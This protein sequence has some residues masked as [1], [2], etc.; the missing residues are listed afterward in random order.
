MAKK[1]ILLKL[2][3]EVFGKPH[4]PFSA[5]T[6]INLIE[7]I[8]EL[9]STHQF[10]IV[11]GGGNLFRGSKQGKELGLTAKNAHQ[12]GMLATIMN[13]VIL[14]DLFEKH[15]VSTELFSAI[16][17]PQVA[18]VINQQAIN[19]A[20]DE[21]KTVLFA[22]GT[23]NPFFTTDT[24]AVLRSLQISADEL[25]KGTSIDGIYTKDPAKNPD[26]QL[27]EKIT[28]AEAIK[29]RLGIMDLTAYSMAQQHKQRIRIFNIFAPNA[30]HNAAQ[31]S[32]FGSIIE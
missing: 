18:R 30:L 32:N 9:Q 14:Q 22:G 21:G 28:Y 5:D 8:K 31:D 20:L 25:W 2:T 4:E 7:Q 19:T 15:G 13:G 12:V 27:I 26:A 11:I 16:S 23:G 3:G 10:G 24:N 29:Q 1:R 17:C 6:V